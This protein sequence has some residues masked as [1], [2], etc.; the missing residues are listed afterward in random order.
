MVAVDV[1]HLFDTFAAG[2]STY[3]NVVYGSP[4]VSGGQCSIPCTHVAG[5][6]QYAGI[7]ST[8]PGGADT[9]SI[10]S[11]STSAEIVTVPSGAG[12]TS[13]TL[14]MAVS[15]PTTGT[16]TAFTYDAVANTLTMG[17]YVGSVDS[18]AVTIA[19][20]GSLHRWWRIRHGA[21]RLYWE[22]S[23]DGVTWTVRR[24]QNGPGSWL[25]STIHVGFEASRTG[26]TNDVAVID[27]VSVHEVTG[28]PGAAPGAATVPAAVMSTGTTVDDGAAVG[29]GTVVVPS[30]SSGAAV[31]A[32]VVP[33]AGVVPDVSIVT[34][35]QSI[36]SPP[37]TV[38]VR[39][40]VASFV[41]STPRAF[42]MSGV[43]RTLGLAGS[44]SVRSL[45]GSAHVV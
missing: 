9:W 1:F 15:S 28:Q 45:S 2:M 37:P 16:Y 13:A 23:T 32:G 26:G 40:P 11:S 39:L 29:S 4:T 41:F 17:N 18:D 33:T 19:Y 24:S 38:F 5:I 27:N 3:W 25:N 35:A 12:A 31:A 22:T 20:I 21:G 43:A 34:S 42:S 7:Q 44:A 14:R 36:M 30:L 10:A 6:P 8:T